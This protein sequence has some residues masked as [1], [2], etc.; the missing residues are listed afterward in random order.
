MTPERGREARF[1]FGP[2]SRASAAQQ[3]SEA[4][5]E[6]SEEREMAL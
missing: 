3:A 5:L 4:L 6:I 2:E 1:S